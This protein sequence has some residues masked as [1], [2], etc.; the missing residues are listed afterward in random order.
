[1]CLCSSFEVVVAI[2]MVI[3]RSSSFN[4]STSSIADQHIYF[5]EKIG[6]DDFSSALK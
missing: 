4:R 3:Y 5:I 1:M 2:K 6:I